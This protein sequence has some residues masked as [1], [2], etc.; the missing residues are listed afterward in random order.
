MTR[1]HGD[2]IKGL[3]RDGRVEGLR[4]QHARERREAK[5]RDAE[6]ADAFPALMHALCNI[7]EERDYWADQGEYSENGP[8]P[9]QA[10]DDWAAEQAETALMACGFRNLDAARAA[11]P[12]VYGEAALEGARQHAAAIE[13]S[14]WK[15]WTWRA[16]AWHYVGQYAGPGSEV[17]DRFGLKSEERLEGL[18]HVACVRLYRHADGH[19]RQQ[20]GDGVWIDLGEDERRAFLDLEG[21]T[22]RD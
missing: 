6:R 4:A 22:V 9:E 13:R 20:F 3:R 1:Y 16:N 18:R 10:F 11:V 21:I 17:E 8:G 2:K 15:V 5:A 14:H 7:I 12:A 19:M